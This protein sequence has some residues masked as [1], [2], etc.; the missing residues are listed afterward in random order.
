MARPRTPTPVLKL[1]GAFKRHP[2]RRAA[3]E[4]EPE[5]TEPLGD[6]P[7][8]FNE[9]LRARWDEILDWAPWLR[10]SDRIEVEEAARLWQDSR[11]GKA[12]TAERKL[13]ASHLIHLGLTPADRSKVQMP[14]VPAKPKNAF[15]A[16]TG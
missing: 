2:E 11:D 1:R 3:R 8:Y 13:L 4:R 15:G 10:V 7:E 9:A 5:V 6:A 12:S 14:G 16:L